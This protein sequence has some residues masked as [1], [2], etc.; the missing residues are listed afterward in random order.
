MTAADRV[1]SEISAIGAINEGAGPDNL[2]PYH[3]TRETSA[4]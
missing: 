3:I 4:I 2:P 1:K